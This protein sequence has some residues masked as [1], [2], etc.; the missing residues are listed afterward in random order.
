MGC[1]QIDKGLICWTL[2]VY[3][4]V[5][6]RV[7]RHFNRVLYSVSLAESSNLRKSFVFWANSFRS[8]SASRC[9][10]TRSEAVE[11]N[12]GIKALRSMSAWLV[13]GIVAAGCQSGTHTAPCRNSPL[14][15]V[16]AF[17]CA[18]VI[19]GRVILRSPVRCPLSVGL[20][21]DQRV[22]RGDC[23]SECARHVE[24][25]SGSRGRSLSCFPCQECSMTV[26]VRLRRDMGPIVQAFYTLTRFPGR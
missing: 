13:H 10:A 15:L 6:L 22:H 19:E 16:L 20:R 4:V 11:S 3:G 17:G 24:V 8:S 23:G 2:L 5:C 1:D 21:E 12:L 25:S 18:A 7:H 14:E 26:I 9:W